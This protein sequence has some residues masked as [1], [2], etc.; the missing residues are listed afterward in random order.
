MAR[1]LIVGGYGNAGWRVAEGLLRDSD[2][3]LMLAGR[4]PGRA[5]Q[6]AATLPIDRRGRVSFRRLDA[7]DAQAVAAALDDI[8]LLIVAAGSTRVCLACAR[9]AISRATDYLDIQFNH[10]KERVLAELRGQFVAAGVVS[11]T[12]GGFHPG[13]P[14]A[15]IRLMASCVPGLAR[16]RVSS[17]IEVDWA[18]LGVLSDSTVSEI[19]DQ[20]ADFRMAELADGHW[21]K[22]T[23]RMKVDFGAPFGIRKVVPM[24]LPELHE[25]ADSLPQLRQV[26]FY[27]GGFGPVIDTA[28]L[29]LVWMAT[30]IP[31]ERAAAAGGRLLVASL[32]RFSKPPFGTV[33]Q[34]D[35][36]LPGGPDRTLMRVGHADA[37]LLTAEPAVSAA[38]MI[39]AGPA[40]PPGLYRQASFVEPVT[41]FR[42]I[43]AAGVNVEI[44][45]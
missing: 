39:L 5:T 37:Y 1:V 35:G 11:V 7:T 41:F 22:S 33:L 31:S 34:L 45:G 44:F 42:D 6:L 14:G 4:N 17:V 8:D 40:H 32:R 27:V 2:A 36:G 21:R 23:R 30:R 19:T 13:V 9:A 38:Q 10:A 12:E 26:G 24:D 29:P 28:V 20:V 3:E 16:A 25:V 15:M 18:S 43:E